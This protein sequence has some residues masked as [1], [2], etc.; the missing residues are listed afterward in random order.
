MMI[1]RLTLR[2]FDFKG[3]RNCRMAEI[4]KTQKTMEVNITKKKKE[5]KRER[6]ESATENRIELKKK[7]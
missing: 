1:D 3:F 6:E 5:N 4:K 2:F 7:N